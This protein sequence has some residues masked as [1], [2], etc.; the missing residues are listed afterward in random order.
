MNINKGDKVKIIAGKYKGK[1][2]IVQKSIVKKGTIIIDNINRATK[3][4]KPQKTNES[5]QIIT[6]EKPIHRSN[7]MKYKKPE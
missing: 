4:I 7:V 3:H 6:I 5:G 1:I 2:G